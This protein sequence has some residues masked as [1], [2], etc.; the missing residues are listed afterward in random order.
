MKS[1]ISQSKPPGFFFISELQ[2]P[3]HIFDL[4]GFVRGQI[5]QIGMT[6]CT[7]ILRLLQEDI[8]TFFVLHP[9]DAMTVCLFYKWY[10]YM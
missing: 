5:F 1:C 6:A 9:E 2:I 4:L 7:G 10:Q 3:G 8:R